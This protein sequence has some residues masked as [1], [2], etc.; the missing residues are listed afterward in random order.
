MR[1]RRS[2]AGGGGVGAVARGLL[3]LLA[4]AALAAPAA[5]LLLST[6]F[7]TLPQ[8]SAAVPT[9]SAAWQIATTSDLPDGAHYINDHTV[10]QDPASGAWHL[11]GIFHAEPADPEHEVLFVHATCNESD[12]LKWGPR[13]FV[14]PAPDD[15]LR[16]ALQARP[17]LNETHIWAPHVLRDEAGARWVMVFQASNLAGDNNRAQIK[18][19]VS[20]DLATWARLPSDAEG[21]G[22]LFT[23]ICVARDPMLVAPSPASGG[24]WSIFYCRCD[25]ASSMLSGVGVRTSADLLTWSAPAMA[26]VLPASLAAPSFNSGASESPFVFARGG[27]VFLSICAASEDYMRTWLFAATA[28]SGGASFQPTP[29]ATLDAHCAEYISE[30]RF[31]TSAGWAK[32]GAFVSNSRGKLLGGDWK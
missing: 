8:P 9:Q 7:A 6:S 22:L 21:G 20:D 2:S 29:V 23:D 14:I 28:G 4:G 27:E 30:G 1:R 5:P 19:A 11:F 17:D 31:V 3:L 10:V 25:N 13:S 26:L 15:P 32:G 18:L 12:P 24:L 16:Y